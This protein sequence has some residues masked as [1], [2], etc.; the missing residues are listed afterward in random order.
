MSIIVLIIAGLFGEFHPEGSQRAQPPHVCEVVRLIIGGVATPGWQTSRQRTLSRGNK[1]TKP[2]AA[3]P[4]E[5]G[6]VIRFER[7]TSCAFEDVPLSNQLSRISLSNMSSP[8]M[9]SNN[10]KSGHGAPN[11]LSREIP[12]SSLGYGSELTTCKTLLR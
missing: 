8:I 1:V 10:D 9:A 6:G 3:E 12:E 11:G 2:A 7:G 4:Y 5:F